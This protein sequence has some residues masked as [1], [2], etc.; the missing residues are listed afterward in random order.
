[1]TADSDADRGVSARRYRFPPLVRAGVF[2]SLSTL[3]AVVLA[4]GGGLTF[5]LLLA[6]VFPYGL[7]PAAVAAVLAFKRVGGLELAE[8][9]P[10]RVGFWR[11]RQARRWFRPIPLLGSNHDHPVPLPAQLDG[12]ELF[13]VDA[14]WITGHARISGFGV[15]VDRAHATV[16]AVLRVAGD[17]QFALATAP[18][19][20]HRV[21]GWGV[22]LAGFCREHSPVTCIGWQEWCTTTPPPHTPPQAAVTV[23]GPPVDGVLLA[24]DAYQDL[25]ERVAPC[26]VRHEV[27]V[28][29][30]VDLSRLRARRRQSVS[31]LAAGFAALSDEV[32]LFTARLEA[33]GL[34]V[35]RPLTAVEITIAT[36]TRSHPPAGPLTARYLTTLAEAVGVSAGELAPMAIEEE[37]GHCRVDGSIHRTWW[38]AGWPRLDVPAAWMDLLLLAGT[39]TRT[40]TVVFEP[41]APSTAANEVEQAATALDA[42]EATKTRHGF[43]VRAVDQRKKQEIAAREQELVAGYGDLAYSGFVHI[44]AGDLDTLDDGSADIEQT[45]AHAGVLL[46]PLDGRHGA[47]WV[48]GLP[49]GRTLTT[50]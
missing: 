15:I 1:M 23:V 4:A 18:E 31:Q 25:L 14:N 27:L 47:G 2:G 9:L 12:L 39:V 7:A 49:L 13:D 48:A 5:V 35:D 20:D 38:V 3:Q 37:W 26:E 11:R 10:A 24:R 40:I 41:V 46:R 36:R 44:T 19:Q 42:A 6:R 22:A 21:S 32:R 28:T 34:R 30:T 16:S 29:V 50:R 45:A 17:G 8:W 33:A 43:R